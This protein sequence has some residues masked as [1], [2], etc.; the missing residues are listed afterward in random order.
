MEPSLAFCRAVRT[1]RYRSTARNTEKEPL[2]NVA[3]IFTSVAATA[4]PTVSPVSKF[5]TNFQMNS[6]ATLNATPMVA[7]KSAYKISWEKEDTKK[8]Y[9]QDHRQNAAEY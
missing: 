8:G 6:P 5:S 1:G 2:R 7:P 9:G 4:P 3:G